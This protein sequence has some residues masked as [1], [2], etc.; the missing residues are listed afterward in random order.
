MIQKLKKAEKTLEL[1][2]KKSKIKQKFPAAY[3]FLNDFNLIMITYMVCYDSVIK[4]WSFTNTARGLGFKIILNLYLK[5]NSGFIKN[6]AVSNLDK[7]KYR[8][9]LDKLKPEDLIDLNAF[10]KILKISSNVDF[11]NLGNFF[12]DT[13]N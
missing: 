7:V 8:K 1:L 4:F 12:I 11:I 2:D 3:E 10:S 6:Y 5:Y 9:T 13:F